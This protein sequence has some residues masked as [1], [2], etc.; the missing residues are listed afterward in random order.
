MMRK[1]GF[2]LDVN[3]LVALTDEDHV[4]HG[5]MTRWFDAAGW[6]N[7]G[8]CAFTEAGLLRVA[9]RPKTGGRSVEEVTELLN[10]LAAHPGYRYWP[11]TASWT[12]LAAPFRGRLFGH[13]QIT[14][15]YL[16][17]LAVE[18]DGVLVTLDQAMTYLAGPEHRQ[19][20]LVLP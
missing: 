19:H 1:P 10:R 17:G 11:I 6:H 5:I 15:A 3:A 7:W 4:H 2:L 18:E 14:D 8:V 12:T 20:L 16:L 13:Q 9:T